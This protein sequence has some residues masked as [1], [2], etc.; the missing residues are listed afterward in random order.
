MKRKKRLSD[1]TLVDNIHA[2]FGFQWF[3][4]RSVGIPKARLE[5]LTKKGRLEKVK[6]MYCSTIYFRIKP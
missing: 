5:E 6:A 2:E 3:T 4:A 1:R